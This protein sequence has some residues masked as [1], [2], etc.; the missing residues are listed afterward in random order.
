MISH[1][2]HDTRMY[3]SILLP[4]MLS[5]RD[6]RLKITLFD[7]FCPKLAVLDET[8]AEILGQKGDPLLS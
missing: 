6:T 3:K 1:C 5:N 7:N 8:A 4:M 2:C